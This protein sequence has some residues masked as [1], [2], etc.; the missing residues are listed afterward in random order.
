VGYAERS[1]DADELGRLL[2]DDFILVGPL[3]FVLDRPQYLG[4]RRS[5]DL[6]HA[7]SLMTCSIFL[8][9][10]TSGPVPT[11]GPAVRACV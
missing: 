5:G 3:G 10:G 7:T 2:A 9:A 6:K 1:G 4:S 11:R 8:T